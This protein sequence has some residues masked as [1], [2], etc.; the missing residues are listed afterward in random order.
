MSSEASAQLDD[1][2]S[3]EVQDVRIIEDEQGMLVL[4]DDEAVEAWVQGNGFDLNSRKLKKNALRAAATGAQA[5]GET[6]AQSGRWVKMTKESADLVAK[7]GST[8]TG[9]VRNHGRIVD[10]IKFEKLSDLKSL[11]DPQMM[12]GLAGMMTQMALEQA[13]EEITD[14]L[15]SIDRKVDDLLQ[16]LQDQQLADLA[17]VAR[18]V[19]EAMTIRDQVGWIT[20]TTWSKIAGCPKDVAVAQNYILLKIEG[21]ARKLAEAGDPSEAK[22][23]SNQLDTD[24]PKWLSMLADT[25][26]LQDKLSVLELD[27]VMVEEPTTSQQHRQGIIVARKHRLHDVEATLMQLNH[28]V[29]QSSD[30]IRA[31]KLFHPVAVNA[32]LNALGKVNRQMMDF[33]V[34][35]GVEAECAT[36][37]TAPRWADV[38]SSFVDDH[39]KQIGA[40]AMRIGSGVASGA[41]H[42]GDGV[43]S[44]AKQIGQ[45]IA[46]FANKDD[47]GTGAGKSDEEVDKEV[48]EET[49]GDIR[50]DGDDGDDGDT[51]DA[52]QSPPQVVEHQP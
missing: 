18:M 42:L 35:L 39:A 7:Y 3:G 22:G 48:C 2:P 49:D 1:L 4:G 20:E 47:K 29:R 38:A 15:K 25:V 5:V 45:G 28:A 51:A 36:I 21:L 40:G 19:D 23:V 27:R 30:A 33:A 14:Y 8:G 31:E 43:A 6:M 37:E 26:Q 11:A 16:D 13:I 41:K 32:T 12:T 17:G 44:G 9:V 46:H 52:R 24:V 10:I 50:V 34:S